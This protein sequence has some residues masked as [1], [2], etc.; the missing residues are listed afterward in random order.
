MIWKYR[1]R[2]LYFVVALTAARSGVTAAMTIFSKDWEIERKVV[3]QRWT[4]CWTSIAIT[5]IVARR[6]MTPCTK[7]SSHQTFCRS[8]DDEIAGMALL[9]P[10]EGLQFHDETRTNDVHDILDS[11]DSHCFS[12]FYGIST[13][14]RRAPW[15]IRHMMS[16]D[17]LCSIGLSRIHLIISTRHAS[18]ARSPPTRPLR[19]RKRTL[20][21]FMPLELALHGLSRDVPRL[22]L[23]NLLLHHKPHI[24]LSYHLDDIIPR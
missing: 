11:S 18:G 1:K 15:L 9:T 12:D 14:S 13:S 23:L 8:T 17:V 4:H 5:H 21:L 19:S 6:M 7:S 16:K 2:S 22:G 10:S 24:L 20:R 3:I